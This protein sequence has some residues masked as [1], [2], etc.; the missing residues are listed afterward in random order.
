[1]SAWKL[2]VRHGP[3][4][5]RQRFDDLDAALDQ[6]RS[7]VEELRAEGP[8][9]RVSMLRDFEPSAQVQARLEISGKGLLRPPTAGV[10]LRGDGSLIAFSGSMAR[11]ELTAEGDE[12]PFDLVRRALE[13]ATS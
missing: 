6:A 11:E 12:T 5:S 1:M 8:L 10:D 7:R 4:V 3:D 9:E 2:T 13:P